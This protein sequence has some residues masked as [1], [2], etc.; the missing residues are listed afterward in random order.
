MENVSCSSGGPSP[1]NSVSSIAVNPN[2]NNN[3]S[4]PPT[5]NATN[6]TNSTSNSSNSS[7]VNTSNASIMPVTPKIEHSP[8]PHP[9]EPQRQTVLMWGTSNPN[10]SEAIT[11]SPNNTSPTSNDIYSEHLKHSNQIIMSPAIEEHHHHHHAQLKWNGNSKNIGIHGG[12]GGYSHHHDGIESNSI[13]SQSLSHHHIVSP[14]HHLHQVSSQGQSISGNSSVGGHSVNHQP[15][16][17]AVGSSCEV[18][19][20]ASYSQYQYF[21]YHHAPQHASTQ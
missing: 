16:S 13:Y 9:Y 5:R 14:E 3:D 18:W 8:P 7:N 17:Q 15:P 2:I 11:R 20:P 21:T 4:E 12:G 19:S 10:S 1:A 6:G